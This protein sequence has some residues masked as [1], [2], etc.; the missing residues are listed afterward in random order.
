MPARDFM[1]YLSIVNLRKFIWLAMTPVNIQDWKWVQ[2]EMTFPWSVPILKVEYSLVPRVE[3]IDY[4]RKLKVKSLLKYVG[5]L[6]GDALH[7]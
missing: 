6:V 2:T 1:N 5:F 7:N 3:S 4:Y